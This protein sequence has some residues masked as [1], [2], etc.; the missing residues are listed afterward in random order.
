M[1]KTKP[2]SK[3]SGTKPYTVSLESCKDYSWPGIKQ[4]IERCVDRIGGFQSYVKKGE[5]VLLK[6]NLLAPRPP[7]SVVCTQ[8]E[9][10]R[11][12]VQL[13]REA[14]GVPLLGDSPGGRALTRGSLE[15]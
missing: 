12:V 14:G 2:A 4:A 9:V 1:S 15:K 11:A 7:E 6:P 8:P 10:A 13:V 5:Q 3:K